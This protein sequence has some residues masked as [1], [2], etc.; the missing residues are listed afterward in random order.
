M[1]IMDIFHATKIKKEN[2]R[3]VAELENTKKFLTP[4][5]MDAL[6]LEKHVRELHQQANSIEENIKKANNNL[7]EIKSEINIKHNMLVDIEEQL[8][9]QDFALYNPKYEMTNSED[10]KNRLDQIRETQK[11]LI[12]SNQAVSGNMNWTVNGS[13]SEGKK[14]GKGHAEIVTS[15]F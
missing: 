1:G 7:A 8:L 14:N 9:Y 10:Y 15:S 11:W 13:T 3:L 12:K 4:E 5:M 2:E 6:N